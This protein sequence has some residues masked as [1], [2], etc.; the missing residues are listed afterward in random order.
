MHHGCASDSAQFFRDDPAVAGKRI[1]LVTQEAALTVF[2]KPSCLA[3]R[4]ELAA[5]I[6][7]VFSEGRRVVSANAETPHQVRRCAERAKVHVPDS[8]LSTLL[9]ERRPREAALP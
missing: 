3:E 9:A 1:G 2:D 6:L 5:D 7:P 8:G 4:F